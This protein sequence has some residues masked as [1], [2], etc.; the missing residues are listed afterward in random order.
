MFPILFIKYASK[1]KLFANNE[2]HIKKKGGYV[3][4]HILGFFAKKSGFS[5][6][7]TFIYPLKFVY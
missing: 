1:E 4:R 5:Q 7:R 2:I 3:K 6:A